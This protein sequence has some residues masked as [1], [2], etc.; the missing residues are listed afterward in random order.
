MLKILV[1]FG[2]RPEV[3][4]LIPVIY[5]LRKHAD[6]IETIICVTSQHK[7]ML[8]DVLNLFDV[9]PDY[10]LDVM[11]DNQDLTNLT[12]SIMQKLQPVVDLVRP[13]WFLVQGDTTTTFVSSLVA[14]YSKIKVAYVEAGLRTRDKHSP[15][16]E[17]IN[18][19]LAS[20]IADVHFAPTIT[21][22]NNLIQEGI[23]PDSIWVTGN[24]VV[25]A[26]ELI[27]Q[28]LNFSSIQDSFKFI[29]LSKK[30]ILVTGHRR[31]SFGDK[32]KNICL[33][34]KE[35]AEKHGDIEIVYPVHLNPNVWNPVHKILGNA[36]NIH[37]IYPLDYLSFVY[38][39]SKAFL[40]VTDSGGVQ[41]EA[42]SLGKYVLVTRDCTERPEG[43]NTDIA[44]LVGRDKNEIRSQIENFLNRS[45]IKPDE[46]KAKNPYGDGKASKRITDVFFKGR[47]DEFRIS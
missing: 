15:F 36:K 44:K 26:L 28:R 25:D 39:M 43:I 18:R 22:K 29:D 8:G 6:K 24:S 40:I 37:L 20:H 41:E 42:P 34:L 31:E 46:I 32:L 47:C 33:A 35:T 2:T 30:I 38:L 9:K 27:L 14:F 5:E 17:E 10:D 4:K 1:V 13:D 16:P 45:A 23:K 21:A 11:K 3:I 19:V 12:A 7:E